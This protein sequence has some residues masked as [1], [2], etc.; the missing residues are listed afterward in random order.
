MVTEFP[1]AVRLPPAS[2]SATRTAGVNAAADAVDAGGPVW[3]A[4]LATMPGCDV[5]VNDTDFP[6][7]VAVA[8]AGP[9]AVPSV[10]VF[11]DAPVASVVV[12][13]VNVPFVAVHVTVAPVTALPPASVT[14]TTNGA[15]G[16]RTRPTCASPDTIAIAAGAPAIACSVNVAVPGTPAAVAVIVS[17]PTVAPSV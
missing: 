13:A 9:I 10:I 3:N 2:C 17:V 4:S 8:V 11:D 7:A 16:D 6:P 12:V 15:N 5:A 14:R 1:A